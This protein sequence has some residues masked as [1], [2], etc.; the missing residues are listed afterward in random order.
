MIE[1]LQPEDSSEGRAAEE[2]YSLILSAWPDVKNKPQWHVLLIPSAKCYGER[3][4]DIDILLF[5]KFA[6]PLPS[7]IRPEGITYVDSLFLAIEVKDTQPDRVRFNGNKVEVRYKSK[8]QGSHGSDNSRHEWEDVTKQSHEQ[9][10]SIINYLGEKG[11]KSP[12]V[13]NIIW[14]RN[15]LTKD[16]PEGRHNIVGSDSSWGDFL[17]KANTLNTQY[18]DIIRA[19]KPDNTHDWHEAVAVFSKKMTPSRLD[20]KRMEKISDSFL[21]S[22]QYAEKLGE[23]LLIF[24][25]RGGTGKTVRLLRLAHHFYEKEHARVLI[26]TYNQ[27]LVSDIKRLFALMSIRSGIGERRIRIQTI[28][29]FM[30]KILAG[31]EI[32][33]PVCDDFFSNYELYKAEALDLMAAV[34]PDDINR[35]ARQDSDTFNWDFILIDEA[36]DW[37]PDERDVLFSLYDFRR[38]ILAD[39]VAQLA[40]NLKPTNWREKIDREQSQVIALREVIRMKKNLCNFVKEFSHQLGL[41]YQD[42]QPNKFAPGGDVIVIEGEYAKDRSIHDELLRRNDKDGNMPVDM[43]FCLPP[44]LKLTDAKGNAYSVVGKKF[45][46]WGFKVWDAVAEDIRESYPTDLEQ[47]R[48]LQYDSCRGLEGWIV[49]NFAFDKFYDYKVKSF[50]PSPEDESAPLFDKESAAHEY[51][52]R[53]LM[54]PLTRAMDTLVIHVTS[55]DHR[56]T[57]ILRNLQVRYKDMVEWIKV[58]GQENLGPKAG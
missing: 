36:Q 7:F 44:T 37:P 26:L 51:A 22:Q 8:W 24:R 23:Q 56:V 29:S 34:R 55:S 16:L 21:A 11:V 41:E 54:I 48:I 10:Y 2:L 9:R 43:L 12:W 13:T 32:I 53:W 20:R 1:I 40:R 14:L 4:E 3:R 46:K 18:G 19:S 15:V 42:I 33:P 58:E 39:G 50:K 38:F 25:G 57:E 52:A 31:L 27:A 30:Y 45:E 47:L 6:N 28:H 49:V 5:A 35:L 17:R